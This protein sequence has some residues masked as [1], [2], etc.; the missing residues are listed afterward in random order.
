MSGELQLK[1]L[2]K[3][4]QEYSNL[5]K[6]LVDQQQEKLKPIL[7][8]MDIKDISIKNMNKYFKTTYE[9]FKNARFRAP[10]EDYQAAISY[11]EGLM[12]KANKTYKDATKGT[13]LYNQRVKKDAIQLVNKILAKGREEGSTPAQRLKAIV[14]TM[15]GEKIPKNTFAKFFTKEELLPDVV[16][17]LLGRVDDPKSIILNTIAE[18]AYIVN[19]YNAY[20]EIADFGMGKFLFRNTDE[21][22]QFLIK[23]NIQG[24]RVLAPIKLSK[25]YNIDFDKLFTNPDKTP[26]LTLPE[27]AK[28]LKD[29]GLQTMSEEMDDDEIASLD[30]I[31]SS[32]FSDDY[33]SNVVDFCFNKS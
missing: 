10:K 21:V 22:Q 16:A 18:Q 15:E 25:P 17:K 20:K 4:L 8:D 13:S 29:T 1:R 9:I 30:L 23:N 28:A 7:K 5:I 14:N 6:K 2:P 33:I 26:L 31:S 19:N 32:M 3:P 24:S 11:F 27:M 12:K